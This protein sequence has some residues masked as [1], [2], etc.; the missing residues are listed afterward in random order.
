MLFYVSTGLLQ[1]QAAGK[2]ER[3]VVLEYGLLG[4]AML[5]AVAWL[6]FQS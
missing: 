2:M 4:S 6:A 3:R 1:H 5:L